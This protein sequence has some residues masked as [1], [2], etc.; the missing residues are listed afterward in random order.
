MKISATTFAAVVFLIFAI[1][2]HAD[3]EADPVCINIFFFSNFTLA[4]CN[5]IYSQ[6]LVCFLYSYMYQVV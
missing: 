5:S 2:V 6:Y 4:R 1:N 3:H